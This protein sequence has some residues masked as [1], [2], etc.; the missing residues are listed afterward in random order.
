MRRQ[1]P[2]QKPLPGLTRVR[3]G[4]EQSDG[5]NADG[6]CRGAIDDAINRR[7]LAQRA[8]SAA[9]FRNRSIISAMLPLHRCGGGQP[10]TTAISDFV[11]PPS[12][13]EMISESGK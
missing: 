10:Q 13:S 1:S 3:A 9:R 2:S 7:P 4:P 6:E 11:S 5:A 8:R 12:F